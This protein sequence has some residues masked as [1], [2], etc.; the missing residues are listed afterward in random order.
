MKISVAGTLALVA[1]AVPTAAFAQTSSSIQAVV[2]VASQIGVSGE[3]NL[4][5]GIGVPG[6]T[7]TVLLE[8]VTAGKWAILG[9]VGA[10]VTLDLTVPADLPVV[11]SVVAAAITP[12]F[13]AGYSST[14]VA[15]GATPWVSPFVTATEDLDAA[16][17]QFF[18]WIA[19]DLTIPDPQAPGN[20][21]ALITLDVAY[22]GN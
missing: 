12:T 15:T 3:N 4:D 13:N 16:T 6:S 11:G 19:G 9:V 17:G 2:N 1:L 18:V 22:T 21:Q 7:R 8:D 10:E 5:F 14:D 20:Y